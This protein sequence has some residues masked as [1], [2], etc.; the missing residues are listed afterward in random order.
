V[1]FKVFT[2]ELA[3]SSDVQTYL[4]EQV[5]ISC[6]SVTR[7]ASPKNGMHIVET[8][9]RNFLRYDGGTAQWRIWPPGPV[10]FSEATN[11]TGLSS[12]TYAAGSPSCSVTFTA[13]LSG[14]GLVIVGGHIE[15]ASSE[16]AVWLGWEMRLN[17]SSGTV[18]NAADDNTALSTQGVDNLKASYMALVSGLTVG[19]VYYLRTMHRVQSAGAVFHR[20]ITWLPSAN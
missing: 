12:S 17:N 5:I 6:T 16:N 1:P 14:K 4:M 2:N 18:V 15:G 20:R 10:E 7:P 9:T 13:P 19:Q 8:D 3:T 11:L